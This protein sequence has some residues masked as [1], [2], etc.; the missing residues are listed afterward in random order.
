MDTGSAARIALV[1]GTAFAL[2]TGVY[3]AIGG[4]ATGYLWCV[5]VGFFLTMAFGANRKELPN[6]LC[7]FL[8][9]YG[10]A[11]LYLYL[12]GVLMLLLPGIAAYMLAELVATGS[13]LFLHLRFLGRTPFNRVPAIFAAV[14]TVYAF[15][16]LSA[17]VPAGISGCVGILMAIGTGKVIEV[18]SC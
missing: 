17:A 12:P 18:L 7:S 3:L 1:R 6:Y 11:A 2:V 4:A 14:A 5:Y 10:W 15:G 9:G 16:T 13:L 8:C